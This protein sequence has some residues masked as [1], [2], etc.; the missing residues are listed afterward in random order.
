MVGLL[1][2]TFNAMVGAGDGLVVVWGFPSAPCDVTV[3]GGGT[4]APGIV[5]LDRIDPLPPCDTFRVTALVIGAVTP[6]SA[7]A[8]SKRMLRGDAPTAVPTVGRAGSRGVGGAA[9]AAGA[10]FCAI[11]RCGVTRAI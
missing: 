2:S 5:A 9:G 7:M 11:D 8:M 3:R 6:E 4:G 1:T 10:A